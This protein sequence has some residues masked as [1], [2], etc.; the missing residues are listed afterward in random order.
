MEI[1]E[2]L[3]PLF[4]DGRYFIGEFVNGKV[5]LTP[6]VKGEVDQSP[7]RFMGRASWSLL[8]Q[9]TARSPPS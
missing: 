7:R 8:L 3:K 5:G 4:Q 9:E 6:A 1:H 2:E